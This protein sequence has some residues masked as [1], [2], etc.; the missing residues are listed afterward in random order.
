MIERGAI[1]ARARAQQVRDYTGLL[2]GRITPTDLDG[3]MDFADRV[4]VFLELKHEDGRFPRGQRLALARLVDA[5]QAA[6]REAVLLV[7]MHAT[8]SD[9]EAASLPVVE[10]RYRGEW[11]LPPRRISAREFIEKFREHGL[12][13]WPDVRGMED[14]IFN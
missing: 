5:C 10:Y 7:L 12:A 2:F 8:D 3:F 4:F 14:Y 6:R 9:I 13:T 1:Y 11:K